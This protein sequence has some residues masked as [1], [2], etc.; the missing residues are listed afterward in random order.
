MR[1]VALA[2]FG[3]VG[4]SVAR[5]LQQ[6]PRH[7]ALATVLTRRAPERRAEWVGGDVRWTE[8]IDEALD[9]ADVFVEL[10]GGLDPAE[11]WIRAA[12]GRRVSV[13]TANKQ[14][15][16]HT[17]P[18]LLALAAAHGCQLRFEGVGRRRRAGHS[19][20]RERAGRRRDDPG[21]RHPQRHLQLH[22]DAHGA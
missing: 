18:A 15:I 11:A 5:V 8:S 22:P 20:H 12:L 17:G 4:R 1:R 13:V 6:S 2:G 14:V 19:G 7:G 10:I 16:A 21:G 9:D 3:T